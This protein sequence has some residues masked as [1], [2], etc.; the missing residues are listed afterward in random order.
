MGVFGKRIAPLG[1]PRRAPLAARL[2]RSAVQGTYTWIAPFHDLL[3]HLVEPA[4]RAALLELAAVTDGEY[5]LEVGVGTGLTFRQLVDQNPSGRT[6]G[7]EYT[8]AMLKQAKRRLGT[9][10]Y[11]YNLTEGTA[12]D[13]TFGGGTFD[14]I[15]SSYMLDMYGNADTALILSEFYR[16]L[17]PGGRVALCHMAVPESRTESIWDLAYR[18]HP[19]LLGGCRGVSLTAPIANAGFVVREALRVSFRTFP[20]EVIVAERQ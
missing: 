1:S 2:P 14:L 4:A 8:P 6:I 11:A 3:A 9:S 10:R 18:A 13:L 17:K 7:V 19:A 16:V 15:V 5:I 12:F 20:S